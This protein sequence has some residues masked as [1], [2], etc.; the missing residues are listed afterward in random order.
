MLSVDVTELRTWQWIVNWSAQYNAA[1]EASLTSF[2][3]VN[4]HSLDCV[5]AVR[6]IHSV[7]HP[8]CITKLVQRQVFIGLCFTLSKIC[9]FTERVTVIVIPSAFIEL[10]I[11]RDLQRSGSYK[12]TLFFCLISL[13]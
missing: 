10:L 4:P 5:C 12:I 8:P 11:D 3:V 13:S 7:Y 2:S 6:I 9:P 1:S